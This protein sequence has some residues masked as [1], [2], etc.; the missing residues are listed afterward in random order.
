MANYVLNYFLPGMQNWLQILLTTQSFSIGRTSENDLPLSDVLVSRQHAGLYVDERGV[1]IIDK[2]SSNGVMV[3]G[4]PI[5]AGEWQWLPLST[6]ILI[7]KTILRVEAVPVNAFVAQPVGWPAAE[8]VNLGPAASWQIPL[9]QSGQKSH[10]PLIIGLVTAVIILICIGFGAWYVLHENSEPD[11]NPDHGVSVSEQA[12][13]TPVAGPPQVIDSLAAIPGGGAVQDDQGVSISIP[14]GSLA[15]GQQAYLE[16]AKL[17]PGMQADIEKAY[18][19]DSLLY[20]VNLKNGEDGTGRVDLNLPAPSPDARLAVLVDDRYLGILE[21]PAEDGVF[22]VSPGLIVPAG[23]QGYPEPDSGAQTPNRYLVVTPKSGTTLVPQETMK[24]ASFARASLAETKACIS[25]FWTVNHCLRNAEGSVYVFWENDVPASLK[26]QEYLRIEDTIAS[27][28]DIMGQYQQKGFTAAA[29]SPSNPAYLI[30]EAGATEPYYSFKTGNVY[31]PWDIIGGISEPTNQCS[32]AHEFFH[33]IEDEEYVMGTA[34]LSNAKSWWLEVSAE[35]GSFML[36]PA[37]I[38]QNLSKYGIVT[39]QANVL[40]FQAA[41]FLWDGSEQARYIHALPFYL[42]LCDGGAGCALSREDW[43]QAINSGTYPM[44]GGAA[45]AYMSNAKDLG[46]YLLGAAPQ[47]SRLDAEIPPSAASGSHYGDYL[48]LKLGGKS[49]W[50]YGMT[51]NQF[52]AS[53]PTEVVVTA[54]IEQGG[55]YPLWVGNGTGTPMGGVSG[56]TGLPA[57]LEIQP[58]PAFWIRQDQNEPVFYPAGTGLKIGS[59][60][61]KL[62]TGKARIVAVAPEGAGTFQAKVTLADFSGDWIAVGSKGVITPVNC[63]GYSPSE[64]NTLGNGPDE[65]LGFFSGYGEYVNPTVDEANLNLVWQ[66][67]L[68]EGLTGSSEVTVAPDKITLHYRIEIPKQA[69]TS[70][71]DQIPGIK[72][73]RQSLPGQERN[74]PGNPLLALLPGAPLLAGAAWFRRR[75]KN[76]W[77]GVVLLV[78]L[79]SVLLYG[80]VGIGIWGNIDTTYTFNRAEYVGPQPGTAS[81]DGNAQAIWKLSDGNVK[82][83]IDLTMTVS[84]DDADGNTTETELPC[85]LTATGSATASIVPE[86]SVT[87]PD[88]SQ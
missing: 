87:P 28:A 63:E 81:T 74:G 19:V 61:D 47:Q 65:L 71:L 13:Q 18:K 79:G 85:V 2:N 4:V 17:S 49:I 50:D 84:S 23:G 1:W 60:S 77:L 5:P 68:P 16:R 53:S 55:V 64:G 38:D 40:G 67:S 78:I 39:T 10:L 59:I 83:D 35:N 82:Y 22:H 12:T 76:T 57:L 51:T 6:D 27:I 37:C 75:R 34:A 36:Y 46:L 58:G 14:E 72:A 26:D 15:N 11:T 9:T 7:G 41:P 31:L 32:I 66:G 54:K 20:A 8:T 62:G 86:G 43:A 56:R 44:E 45:T 3:G 25:E 29:I 42:S 24:L 69:D 80:C 70:S 30:V 52:N 48:I 21:T 33:W 73:I 88:I